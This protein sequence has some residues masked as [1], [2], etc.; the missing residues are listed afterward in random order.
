MPSLP[1]LTE[2]DP[3]AFGEGSLDPLGLSAIADRLA[4]EIAPDITAR[5][6]RVR[7]VTAIAVGAAMTVNFEDEFASD[8][9]TPPYL[10]YEWLVV[11]SFARRRPSH[12]TE[13]VPGILKARNAL[14]RSWSTHLDAGSYLQ[15][16]KVFGFHGVYKRFGRAAQFVDNQVLPLRAGDDLVRTWEREQ[17][18]PGFSDRA[19]GTP[20]ARLASR[21]IAE[22]RAALHASQVKTVPGARLWSHLSDGLHP[23][24]AGTRERRLLWSALVDEREPVRRELVLALEQ[25]QHWDT[26]AQ[27]LRQI[28]PSASPVLRSRL[29]A[30]NAYEELSRLL[31]GVFHAIRI[32]STGQGTR[33]VTSRKLAGSPAVESAVRDLPQAYASAARRLDPLGERA[34][35]EGHLGRF[36]E[37]HQ[38]TSLIDAVVDH[39]EGVQTGK[40]GKRPWIERIGAGYFVRDAYRTSDAGPD[41]ASYI[42][43]YRVTAL[44]SFIGDLR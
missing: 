14:A 16:P 20:G 32:A 37:P 22:I 19:P 8:G 36:S 4:D 10:A 6:S 21:L 34:A 7:F 12:E 25:R 2:E 38:A 15:V 18:F 11:E 43:P 29:R 33:P 13:G 42:H 44:T 30:I 31:T 40:G 26:E 23:N 35:L 39:H 41:Q 9:K 1:F 24:G 27:A 5:M 3:D 28:T 17:G